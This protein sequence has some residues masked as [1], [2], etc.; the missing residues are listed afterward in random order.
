MALGSGLL[1][2]VCVVACVLDK[3]RCSDSG[4]SECPCSG[5]PPWPQTQP[6]PQDCHQLNRTFR[7]SCL[8]GYLRMAGTSNLIKCKPGSSRWSS[9]TL[10]CK[11]DPRA[12]ASDDSET[13]ATTTSVEKHR[14]TSEPADSLINDTNSDASLWQ[15]SSSLSGPEITTAVVS[16]LAAIVALVGIG[17]LCKM[18]RAR[19]SDPPQL[20]PEDIALN[21]A[22]S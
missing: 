14:N 7:Y 16:V 3:A 2:V 19:A 17:L 13:E 15:T 12:G 6:P 4:Q 9:P 21:E 1:L 5:I 18:R 8:K 10:K 20:A 22:T 11:R